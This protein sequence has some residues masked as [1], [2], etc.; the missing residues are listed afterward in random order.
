MT[1][2]L[3]DVVTALNAE[4]IVD[5]YNHKAI[6][7]NG[8]VFRVSE[9]STHFHFV[10]MSQYGND[11]AV[12]RY[13]SRE[14]WKNLVTDINVSKSKDAK[15]IAKEVNSRF[16]WEGFKAYKDQYKLEGVEHENRVLR[17]AE[18]AKVLSAILG[19]ACY[20]RNPE[21]YELNFPN[22]DYYGGVTVETNIEFH[23]R[24]IKDVTLAAKLCRL[25]RDHYDE[26]RN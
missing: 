2:E 24:G 26:K 17:I 8:F 15:R 23:L 12:S 10:A 21:S 16:D 13:Q 1:T 7:I 22:G 4:Q 6:K 18:N 3:K 9:N 25:I 5:S 20:K 19:S 11:S 14:I